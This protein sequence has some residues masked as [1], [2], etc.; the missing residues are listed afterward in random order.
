[1]S[2]KT[3]KL[4]A[5]SQEGFEGCVIEWDVGKDYPELLKVLKGKK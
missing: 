1:M 4:Y 3:Y 5:D 2:E